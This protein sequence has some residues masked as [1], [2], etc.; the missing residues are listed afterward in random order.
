MMCFDLFPNIL[1]ELCC[2]F[3]KK[4]ASAKWQKRLKWSKETRAGYFTERIGRTKNE[5]AKTKTRAAM[6]SIR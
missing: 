1:S 6:N 2:R 5:P 3:N 4:A